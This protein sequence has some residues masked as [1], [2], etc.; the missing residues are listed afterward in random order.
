MKF[1]CEYAT[2]KWY[3]GKKVQGEKCETTKQ[4]LYAGLHEVAEQNQE[5]LNMVPTN[6][7]E[8]G[9]SNKDQN[10]EQPS[11]SDDQIL[12]KETNNVISEILNR[13]KAWSNAI[14]TKASQCSQE[15]NCIPNSDDFNLT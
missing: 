12:H 11:E 14:S 3:P 6:Y 9:T 7:N 4:Q 1:V 5:T 8:I 15:D 2:I 10:L 13:T